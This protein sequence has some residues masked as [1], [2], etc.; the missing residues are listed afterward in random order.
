MMR[1]TTKSVAL[2]LT[3]AAS[4]AFADSFSDMTP[5]QLQEAAIEA[6]NENDRRDLMAILKEM[7]AREMH[8][9][10]QSR[11]E[12]CE[13]EPKKTGFLTSRFGYYGTA[14]QAYFTYLREHAMEA[15]SCAC[16]MSH[17]SFDEFLSE[18]FGFVQAELD[19]P[20]FDQIR[21][22]LNQAEGD[23]TD[24]YRAFSASNCRKN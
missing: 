14:R 6:V 8:F 4:A 5:D 23:V 22:Y 17:M 12:I 11:S 19:K 10:R 21:D 3:L 24:K 9:F 18:K 2:A 13:R 20:K 1:F 15:G 16:L 7:Q